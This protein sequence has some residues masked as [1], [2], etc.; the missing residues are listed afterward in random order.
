MTHIPTQIKLLTVSMHPMCGVRDCR[1]Q[2]S[3]GLC[4]GN[5]HI[6]YKESSTAC[7]FNQ[8]WKGTEGGEKK[9]ERIA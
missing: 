5:Y 1:T 6:M 7:D 2:F 4:R 8:R 3:Q 9:P